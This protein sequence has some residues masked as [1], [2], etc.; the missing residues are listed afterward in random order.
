LIVLL[1]V[2]DRDLETSSDPLC[3]LS[4]AGPRRAHIGDVIESLGVAGVDTVTAMSFGQKARIRNYAWLQDLDVGRHSP[5]RT[6]VELDLGV[7]V[8]PIAGHPSSVI[9]VRDR[10]RSNWPG[11]ASH[12]PMFW[13]LANARSGQPFGTFRL[14]GITRDREVKQ[15]VKY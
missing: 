14:R 5:H 3:F 4:T 9:V 7:N 10:E 2:T 11:T 15:V 6:M 13:E 12:F 8:G 1:Q